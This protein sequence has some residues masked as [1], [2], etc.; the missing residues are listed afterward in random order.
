MIQKVSGRLNISEDRIEF[1]PDNMTQATT[2]QF[3]EEVQY[4]TLANPSGGMPILSLIRGAMQCE[5][6]NDPRNQQPEKY[7][8]CLIA[9]NQI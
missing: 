3:I 8:R 6:Y 1:L 5:E 7:A 9:I 4:L 2:Q